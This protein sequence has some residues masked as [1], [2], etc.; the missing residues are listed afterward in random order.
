M[1]A[2][3]DILV[4]TS[5]D[6]SSGFSCSLAFTHAILTNTCEQ[7]GNMNALLAAWLLWFLLRHTSC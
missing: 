5:A 2:V 4:F 6:G 3:S 1:L 7:G